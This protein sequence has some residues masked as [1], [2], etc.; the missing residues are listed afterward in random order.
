MRIL[1]VNTTAER[2]GG[3]EAFVDS[4]MD[5]QRRHGHQPALLA[6]TVNAPVTEPD[7]RLVKRPAWDFG[8]M[9]LDP[10]FETAAEEFVGRFRPDV[11]HLHNLFTLSSGLIAKLA[12][13]GIPMVQHVHDGSS[14]CANS[15]LTLPNGRPC[16]GG[17]GTKCVTSGCQ[18]NYPYD[19]RSLLA[20]SKRAEVLR[21]SVDHWIAGSQALVERC[22]GVGFTPVS[23]IPI[24][25]PAAPLPEPVPQLGARG[26]RV[27]S[28][29]R[30]VPEKGV[31]DL[32]RAWPMIVARQ[33][34]AE[35]LIVGE[36]RARGDWEALARSLGLDPAR[37]F[38]GRISS[39]EV[40]RQMLGA[41]VL[42]A[43]SVWLEGYGLTIVEAQRAGLPVV[44]TALGGPEE[45]VSSSGCGLLV[46]ARNPNAIAAAVLRLLEEDRL[47]M[48]AAEG[49]MQAARASGGDG[50]VEALLGVYAQA[51]A[52]GTAH[53]KPTDMDALACADAVMREFERVQGWA[54]DMKKH[55]EYLEGIGR[56]DQPVKSFARHLRFWIRSKR[57]GST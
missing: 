22:T 23:K 11:I 40:R 12:K 50:P 47:W 39:E 46:E 21:D 17:V 7:R 55:I 20:I 34:A 8:R 35:L 9:L 33:P 56:G 25:S 24:W 48:Q 32:L 16:P 10:E 15:W 52:R 3:T 42:V 1:H 57:S 30:L 5:W 38:L 37:I 51:Q 53:R 6:P 44:A 45:L 29:G 13:L 54:L 19:G 36:G 14:F 2:E 18:S 41:R 28:V 43:P 27:L 31:D 26:K 49:G 4:V